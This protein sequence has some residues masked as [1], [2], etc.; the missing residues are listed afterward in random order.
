MSSPKEI[1]SR[2]FER[3]LALHRSGSSGFD[4]TAHL[5]AALD[6]VI[7]SLWTSTALEL[8]RTCVVM[9]LG[10]YG[11]YELCPRSD[12]D[13]MLLF[14][15]EKT[16]QRA[17]PEAQRF[18]H[19]LWDAGFDLGHSVRTTKDCIALSRSDIDSWASVLES[20]F[21]CG[22]KEVF[23]DFVSSV[24][25]EIRKR[26][27]PDFVAAV[28]NGVRDRHDKYGNAVKLLEPNMKKSAGGLRDVHALL[29][30]FR[31]TNFEF[32]SPDPFRS[33]ESACRLLISRLQE[34]DLADPEECAAVNR[35][36]DFLLRARNETH[37]YANTNHDTLDFSIQRH[38]AAGLGYGDDPQF[39]FVERFMRDYYLHARNIYRLNRRLLRIHVKQLRRSVKEKQ[40]ER[41][42]D[43]VFVLRGPALSFHDR[44]FE[45]A[46]RAQI[47]HACALCGRHGIDPGQS[48]QLKFIQSTQS[49]GIFAASEPM[50]P[51]TAAAFR[52]I[53]RMDKGIAATL[54]VMNDFDLLGALLPEWRRLVA[55]FQHSQY[56]Y[57]TADAHTLIA[58]EHA[59]QLRN[60]KDLLGDVFRS[61][62]RKDVL[63]LT[64]L[65]H[66]IEKPNGVE[67]HEIRGA[68]TAQQI[69]ARIGFEDDGTIP[70]LIRH[71]LTMEQVAFRRNIND[72]K[73]IAEFAGLF[74]SPEQL[75]YLF[76]VTYSDLSA[77]NKSVWTSWKE[78][79]LQELYRR[80]RAVLERRLP[81]A[82]AV[83]F[84][85]SEHRQSVRT[86]LDGFA[87]A[88]LRS[89]VEQHLS[90]LHN[91]A[92]IAIFSEQEIAGHVHAAASVETITVLVDHE[93][94]YTTLTAVTHDAPQLLSHL[95]G[96]L[97]A[98]D[99]N[100]F[101]AHIFTRTD[102]MV[103]D[104]FRVTD[105]ATGK[106]LSEHQA[107]KI[108]TDFE[109]VLRGT[110]TIDALFERHQRRW[111][112]RPRPMLHPNIKRDVEFEESADY[113]IIDVSAPDTTGF[114]YR[115]TETISGLGLAIY[116]AK[117]ATRVDGIVDSF[118]VLESDGT[119]VRAGNRKEE[120]RAVILDTIRQLEEVQLSI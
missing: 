46:S 3:I 106:R 20:R 51:D 44:S 97:S 63:F 89:A 60:Q 15:D 99:A 57:Y 66:D 87:D 29:W 113:T 50:N 100:I 38:I 47:V 110:E 31:S 39:E 7:Q 17:A 73:T 91:E 101:D 19:A 108:I 2:H 4:V 93:V 55:F 10:G 117:I 54:M 24:T 33:P 25:T 107:E 40:E 82:E 69:M 119:P 115:V 74:T 118:Y 72:P 21:I 53:L 27:N 22:G 116:F 58:L 34:N 90:L 11:R 6:D 76:V 103:I 77:V 28:L 43:D 109:H 56:H 83:S 67:Q 65:L 64:I 42:L 48:L 35:A 111:K 26:P 13:L 78:M 84:Q 30:M 104:Q 41:V 14:P 45:F 16:K 75:D 1:F 96:V 8:D 85:Q 70:F 88:S 94:S 62:P 86:M 12:I 71:H 18:L 59:E 52:D 9:A 79:L 23:A 49:R 102:S 32:L 68:D 80:T 112:R 5:S 36:M 95:C 98:N 61:L 92:Y 114:L 81:F 105:I 120:I 37:Y